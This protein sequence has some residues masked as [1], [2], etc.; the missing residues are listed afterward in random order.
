MSMRKSSG[1]PVKLSVF[2]G[3][4]KRDLEAIRLQIQQAILGAGHIPDGMELWASAAQPTLEMI[5]DKLALCDVHVIILGHRYGTILK[6][7]TIGF[8]EWEYTQ[9]RDA[10]RPVISFL[11][12]EAAVDEAWSKEK[13]PRSKEE[14][15]HYER[16][17]KELQSK[18][19]CKFYPNQ[20]MSKIDVHVLNALNEVISSR[21]LLPFPGWIRAETKEAKVAGALQDN[22]FLKRIMDRVVGFHDVGSRI[23]KESGAKKAAA[24]MFWDSMISQ[25]ERK[26]HTSVFLESGSSLVYVSESFEKRK[27]EGRPKEWKIATNNALALLQLLLFVDGEIQR[28]PQVAPDPTDPY[29]A[30]FT[31]RCLAA[32]QNP[33]VKPRKTLYAEEQEA[34]KEFITLLNSGEDKKIIL[35]TASGWDTTHKIEE[36]RGPHVGSHA[37]M[38]FKR[39]IFLTGQPV[40][41]FLSRNKVDPNQKLHEARF[42]CRKDD[43]A[44]RPGMRYCYPVF[45]DELPLMKALLESPVA[46]CIGYE[47]EKEESHIDIRLIGEQLKDVLR[48]HLDP[49]RFDMEYAAKEFALE[50]GGESAAIMLANEKFCQMF[51]PL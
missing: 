8:T 14:K 5:A 30:I 18:S 33:P 32:Y 12:E 29:G 19:V 34:I 24:E 27:K 2:L 9:S 6:N 35:A 36:F 25:L 51:P 37:N 15:K 13:E 11:L 45:G 3:S 7:E 16:F 44:P 20:E 48:P 40:I 22:P 50:D 28:K 4:P 21:Q 17:R 10:K 49:A 43:E 47:K 26:T 46:L 31:K 42:K 41:L 38:L 23:L 1:D 39:A